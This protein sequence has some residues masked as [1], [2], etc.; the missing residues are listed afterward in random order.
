MQVSKVN[1]FDQA[2]LETTQPSKKPLTLAISLLLQLSVTSLLTLIPLL[3]TQGLPAAAFKNLLVAPTPPR[4]AVP[5]PPGSRVAPKLVARTFRLHQLYAPITIPKNVI[6]TDRLASAP[7]IAVAGGILD[8]NATPLIAV[9]GSTPPQGP[10]PAEST[11]EKKDP[12]RGPVH[13]GTLS[14]ANLLRKVM[15]VYPPLAKSARVQGTVE[16]TALISKEGNIENLKLVHGHPLLVNAAK[17][18]VEQWKYRP[19]LLNGVPVEV[20]TDIIVNFTLNQ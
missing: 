3:Y 12:P 11:P 10:P 14:E 15:P 9:I 1:M 4:A 17:E 18:A 2:L 19:T 16:F 13:I 5:E 8:T 6:S 20:I 7:D